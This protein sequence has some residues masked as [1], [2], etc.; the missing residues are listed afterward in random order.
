[1]YS[2]K[3]KVIKVSSTL[4]TALDHILKDCQSAKVPII[5][6]MKGINITPAIMKRMAPYI[7]YG[8]AVLPRYR[9]AGKI[10]VS[11]IEKNRILK[12]A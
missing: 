5:L 9:Q 1:M 10:Y 3:K 2:S 11:N 4:L 7:K 6:D 12:K 8:V